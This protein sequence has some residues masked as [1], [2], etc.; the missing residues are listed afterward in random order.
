MN[1]DDAYELEYDKCRKLLEIY[2]QK[3]SK[4]LSFV[5]VIVTATATLLT[6]TKLDDSYS[7]DMFAF[8]LISANFILIFSIV[9][10]A[11]EKTLESYMKIMD[12]KLCDQCLKWERYISIPIH[13]W[14]PAWVQSA[15]GVM[16]NILMILLFVRYCYTKNSVI[17][18]FLLIVF[19][20]EEI[21]LLILV[22]YFFIADKVV[23]FMYKRSLCMC[24]DTE[25][26]NL[27]Q[28]FPNIKITIKD[29]RD[30]LSIK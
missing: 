12:F 8:L 18:I 21:F 14:M 4:C 17:A 2:D 3:S 19:V 6:S 7:N 30:I 22:A 20:L 25:E 29:L 5:M 1:L 9:Y 26:K 11:E 16:G 10:M 23:W 13:A 15:A 24:K 27:N 28:Y